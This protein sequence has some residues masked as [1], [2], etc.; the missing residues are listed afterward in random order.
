MSQCRQT[1]SSPSREHSLL[2]ELFAYDWCL[3]SHVAHRILLQ[4]IRIELVIYGACS[5]LKGELRMSK[6]TNQVQTGGQQVTG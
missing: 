4:E 3:T 5:V 6:V 2:G 1:L